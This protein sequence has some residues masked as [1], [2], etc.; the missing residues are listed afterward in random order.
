MFELFARKLEIFQT[1]AGNV[2][3]FA[4]SVVELAAREVGGMMLRSFYSQ[5]GGPINFLRQVLLS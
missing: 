2:G 4:S 3:I 5:N 1:N